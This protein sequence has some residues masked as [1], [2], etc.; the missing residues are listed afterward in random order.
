ML[1]RPW[2][3]AAVL[4]ALAAGADAAETFDP[5]APSFDAADLQF[6]AH[7]QS[8][9]TN[10]GDALFRPEG[11]GPFP[12]LVVMPTCSGRSNSLHMYDW[13]QRALAKGYA[14]LVVDP[15]SQRGARKNY[16][17][18]A[19]P[20]PRLLK[21]AFDAADHLRSQPFVDPR[22]IGLIGFSQGAN[23]AL[24]ASGSTYGRLNGSEPFRAIIAVYPV[25]L[26]KGFP[27]GKD[28]EA[29][30]VNFVPE[31]VV[32][33]LLAEVGDQ[34]TEAISAMNG[35]P[36]LL[37]RQKQRRAPVEYATYHATHAWDWRELGD[38]ADRTKGAY[39]QPVVHSYSAEAAE[40]SSE[41]AFN[42]LDRHMKAR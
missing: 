41:D 10:V 1:I 22:R 39:G 3:S 15:L 9:G 24:G 19:A 11:A 29:V 7:P 27:I 36:Q 2:L 6:P 17:P 33:P 42:F 34:D 38:T 26:L 35:C 13:A 8:F 30:D 4:I 5:F 21:D 32:V 14:V 20:Y 37:D 40:R 28:G 12:A 23:T 25:C 18:R 16:P 31:E